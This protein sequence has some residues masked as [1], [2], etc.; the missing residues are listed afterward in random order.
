MKVAHNNNNYSNTKSNY[1]PLN[2][3]WTP[4]P[5]QVEEQE[6]QNVQPAKGR[7]RFNIPKEE[8]TTGDSLFVVPVEDN[9]RN[10]VSEKSKRN[11]TKEEMQKRSERRCN[12]KIRWL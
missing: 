9:Q 1:T 10:K 8:S 11:L 7:V 5:C 3:D 6:Q 12:S 4:P 2:L